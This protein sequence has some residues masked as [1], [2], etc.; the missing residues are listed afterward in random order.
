M[1]VALMNK[2]VRLVDNPN[3][4]F[5]QMRSCWRLVGKSFFFG[6]VVDGRL[7]THRQTALIGLNELEKKTRI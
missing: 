4:A 5:P 3:M 2:Q 6:V 7:S 1:A